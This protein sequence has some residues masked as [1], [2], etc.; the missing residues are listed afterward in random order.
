MGQLWCFFRVQTLAY[1]GKENEPNEWLDR[2]EQGFQKNIEIYDAIRDGKTLSEIGAMFHNHY[3]EFPRPALFGLDAIA[4][5]YGKFHY[6][7]SN[8]N[9]VINMASFATRNNARAVVSDNRDC[10]IYEGDWQFWSGKQFRV[11]E[12]NPNKFKTIHFDR[13]ALAR[14]CGIEAI[15]RPLFATLIGNRRDED[16]RNKLT[17]FAKRLDKHGSPVAK[18]AKYVKKLQGNYQVHELNFKRLSE[19]VFQS[20]EDRYIRFL[21]G[22]ID[23]YDLD[24]IPDEEHDT[25]S[26]LCSSQYYRD[27]SMIMDDDRVLILSFYDLRGEYE[28]ETLPVLFLNWDRRKSGILQ[29]VWRIESKPIK[30]FAK[31]RFDGCFRVRVKKPIRPKSNAIQHSLLMKQMKV[32]I[33]SIISVDVPDIEDL[34]C[35]HKI[36]DINW[37]MLAFVMGFDDVLVAVIKSLPRAFRLVC[38]TLVVLV[39]VWHSK[40]TLTY[41]KRNDS[42]INVFCSPHLGWSFYRGR[43]RWNS[44]DYVHG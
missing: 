14:V 38:T 17:E 6:T 4:K 11:D 30:A 27:V 10:Y 25:L 35:D 37:N 1:T 41:G 26:R 44:F 42:L 40:M 21:K 22:R 32:F 5:K 34:Y 18:V 39:K 28:T 24:R 15:H 36:S 9:L 16:F 33:F 13:G 12:Q 43:S 7:S 3:F 20:C 2:F 29:K 8:V 31:F 19:D 23:S